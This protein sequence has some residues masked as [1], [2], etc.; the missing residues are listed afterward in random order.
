[1]TTLDYLRAQHFERWSRYG[2]RFPQRVAEAFAG[3]LARAM[4]ASDEEV[5]ATVATGE[6]L[7]TTDPWVQVEVHHRSTCDPPTPPDSLSHAVDGRLSS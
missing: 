5:L 3:D 7:S 4:T 2:D 1:M 6:H